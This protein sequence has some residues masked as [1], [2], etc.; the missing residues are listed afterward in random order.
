MSSL[1]ALSGLLATAFIFFRTAIAMLYGMSKGR[2]LGLTRVV[3][4]ASAVGFALIVIFAVVVW[5]L[6]IWYNVRLKHW[7]DA[8]EV[9]EDNEH[10]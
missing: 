5:S 7:I 6:F 1:F 4:L 2:K 3:E 8:I 10:G 9:S